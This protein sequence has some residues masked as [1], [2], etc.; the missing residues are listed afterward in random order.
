MPK[1]TEHITK[2]LLKIVSEKQLQI[3]SAAEAKIVRKRRLEYVKDKYFLMC[4]KAKMCPVC[5]SEKVRIS[6]VR[7]FHEKTGESEYDHTKITCLTCDEVINVV[8]MDFA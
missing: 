2:E 5:G 7:V 6:N 8:I 4:V 3:F 1:K